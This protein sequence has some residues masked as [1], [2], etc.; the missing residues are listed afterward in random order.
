MMPNTLLTEFQSACRAAHEQVQMLKDLYEHLCG[1]QS[2]H[3]AASIDAK[4]RVAEL[5]SL[6][7]VLSQKL[8]Q[9]DLL[10]TQPDPERESLLELITGVKATVT[11]EE[12]PAADER[13]A[14]EESEL[15]QHIESMIEH[16]DD[17]SL[18]EARARTRDVI[19]RLAGP[20]A[21]DG[22]EK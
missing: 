13:L 9:Q 7:E 10:P 5:T 8:E 18:E 3:A 2:H 19:A 6:Q 15:L 16:D 21:W 20:A 22:G 4:H 17:A 1:P 12:K 11:G 14:T